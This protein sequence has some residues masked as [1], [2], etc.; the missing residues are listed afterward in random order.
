M[1]K[2]EKPMKQHKSPRELGASMTTPGGLV[3]KV[4]YLHPDE[5]EALRRKA[6]EE[7][8]S[9][10]DIIREAVRRLLGIEE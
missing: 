6:F 1:G 9:E 8:R 10:S 3:R 5:V 7:H 2:N 4:A